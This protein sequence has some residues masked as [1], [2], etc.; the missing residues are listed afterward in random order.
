MGYTKIQNQP[1]T[2]PNNSETT[3][4]KQNVVSDGRKELETDFLT[5]WER[6]W[7]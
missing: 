6:V 1:K 7:R 3:R 2:H 5:V 4:N